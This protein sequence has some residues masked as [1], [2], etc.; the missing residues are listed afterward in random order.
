MVHCRRSNP[1]RPWT[2]AREAMDRLLVAGVVISLVLAL[3]LAIFLLVARA[4]RNRR[5]REAAD[6]VVSV[7]ELI[8]RAVQLGEPTQLN[9]STDDLDAYG[10]V[11][12]AA[13]ANT[14]LPTAILPKLPPSSRAT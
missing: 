10:R 4:R 13:N 3:G 7:A 5:R 11:K 8:E 6:R 12:P 2:T 1:A 14:D 9:W